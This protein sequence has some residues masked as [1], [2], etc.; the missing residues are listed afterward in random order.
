MALCEACNLPFDNTETVG[1]RQA[2]VRFC[3][4]AECI[5][6]RKREKKFYEKSYRIETL[7]QLPQKECHRC[8]RDTPNHFGYCDSCIGDISTG[9]TP[10]AI[11]YNVE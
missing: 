7:E 5:N 4:R 1:R 3:K 10:E 6:K 9:Y 2:P 8:G 11:L